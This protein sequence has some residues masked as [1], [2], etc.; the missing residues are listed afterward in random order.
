MY[1]KI[2][3]L[4]EKDKCLE[5]IAVMSLFDLFDFIDEKDVV[6]R[7]KYLEAS[8]GLN[9]FIKKIFQDLEFLGYIKRMQNG[10]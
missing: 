5:Y 4:E 2:K 8:K 10:E 7:C 6:N 1:K 9:L 3:G